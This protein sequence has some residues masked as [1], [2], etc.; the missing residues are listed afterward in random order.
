MNVLVLSARHQLLPFARRLANDGHSVETVVYSGHKG[1]YERAYRGVLDFVTSAKDSERNEKLGALKELAASGKMTVIADHCRAARDFAGAEALFQQI[2]QKSDPVGTVRFGAWF[3]GAEF[4]A[5]HLLIVDEGMQAG[6]LGAA[7]D[8]SLTLVRVSDMA[9]QERIL[10]LAEPQA[11]ELVEKEFRGLVQWTVEFEDSELSLGEGRFLGW[12]PLHTHAFVSELEDFGGLLEGDSPILKKKYTVALHITQAP[13][14][15][16]T[17]QP[18]EEVPVVLPEAAQAQMFWHDIRV[19]QEA[20]ELRTAGLDGW[21]GV[22]H[23]GG[24]SFDLAHDLALSVAGSIGLRE[25]QF[26]MDA[27]AQVR[28]VLGV[29][30]SELGIIAG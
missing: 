21:V 18:P 19:D 10:K 12:P 5:P 28:T 1:K 16:H 17:G 4:C 27:G 22:A 24:D 6:G 14:P 25:K 20:R 8:G 11:N 3:D 26:R 2:E 30:E 7:G 23:A 9:T 29:L 15:Y 13:Y